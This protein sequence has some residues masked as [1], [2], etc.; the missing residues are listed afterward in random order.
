[1]TKKDQD[2]NEFYQDQYSSREKTFALDKVELDK[3]Q[4]E[5]EL[6]AQKQLEQEVLSMENALN[7]N[8]RT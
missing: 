6:K 2:A 7:R 1:M 3:K 4:K 8:K 5:R